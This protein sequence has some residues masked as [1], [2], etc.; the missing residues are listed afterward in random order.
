M[1]PRSGVV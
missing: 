1:G